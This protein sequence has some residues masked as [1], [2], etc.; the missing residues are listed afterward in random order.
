MENHLQTK[1]K[2]YTSAEKD[3][4]GGLKEEIRKTK[5]TRQ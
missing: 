5:T 4:N 2:K 3:D 1:E